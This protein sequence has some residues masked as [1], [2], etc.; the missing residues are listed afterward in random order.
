MAKTRSQ[1]R[2]QTRKEESSLQPNLS[3]RLKKKQPEKNNSNRAIQ[4]RDF[5]IRLDRLKPNE[6]AALIEPNKKD[7]HNN[8]DRVLRPK[9]N[10]PIPIPKERPPKPINQIVALS[11]TA[12]FTSKALRIWDALRK[13]HSKAKLEMKDI[14]LARMSGHRPWPA[15][16]TEFNRRGTLLF[17]FGTN[18]T[19]VVKR[20]E[21]VQLCLCK[22]VIEE[23]LK[24]PISQISSKTVSY[25]MQFV[26]ACK[27]VSCLE[28]IN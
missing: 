22:D 13:T 5:V 7:S 3:R 1:T 19:G 27:E 9:K 26:K 11:Q 17:F 21:I 12:L 15:R 28:K 25:H 20:A 14:V 2:A 16:I 10:V 6:I 4:I 23:Y 24:V 8:G 18:E